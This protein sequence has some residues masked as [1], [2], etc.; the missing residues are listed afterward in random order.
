MYIYKLQWLDIG[1]DVNDA[2]FDIVV[3]S[4]YTSNEN[5][6]TLLGV[7]NVAYPSNQALL[8]LVAKALKRSP[9]CIG[10]YRLENA[11]IVVDVQ[12]AKFY[13]LDIIETTVLDN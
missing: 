4:R 13:R 1:D 9:D 7:S 12:Y 3:V 11:L 6:T 2:D 10:V 8:A 5:R